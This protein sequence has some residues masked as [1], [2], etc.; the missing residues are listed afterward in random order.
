MTILSIK[1][2]DLALDMKLVNFLEWCPNENFWNPILGDVRTFRDGKA[3]A[4]IRL[5]SRILKRKQQMTVGSTKDK[6]CPS[7]EGLSR[8]IT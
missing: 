1:E 5:G 7:R 3:E 8:S 2:E 6:R 4:S